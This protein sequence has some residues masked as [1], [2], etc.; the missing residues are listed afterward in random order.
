L[1]K[2]AA[3]DPAV[4]KLT[5]EVQNLLKPRSVYQDPALVPRVITILAEGARRRT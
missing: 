3:R 2:L 1:S 5:V 4:P